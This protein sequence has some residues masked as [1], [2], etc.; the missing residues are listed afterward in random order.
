MAVVELTVLYCSVHQSAYIEKLLIIVRSEGTWEKLG[1]RIMNVAVGPVSQGS[2]EGRYMKAPDLAQG[3]DTIFRT[4]NETGL[5]CCLTAAHYLAQRYPNTIARLGLESRLLTPDSYSFRHMFLELNKVAGIARL[6]FNLPMS[7]MK[8]RVLGLEETD[9]R[10]EGSLSFGLAGL[11][12]TEDQRSRSKQGTAF[13]EASLVVDGFQ[14]ICQNAAEKMEFSS[15]EEV[16]LKLAETV[17]E[18]LDL[19]SLSITLQE[20]QLNIRPVANLRAMYRG[21]ASREL[22]S[23]L[24]ANQAQ[25]KL[26]LA[27]RASYGGNEPKRISSNAKDGVLQEP[28]FNAPSAFRCRPDHPRVLYSEDRLL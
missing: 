6:W 7:A 18:V 11:V 12:H 5:R 9:V 1:A 26:G 13:T 8:V 20:V 17:L 23:N 21:T 19:P 16:P 15:L 28:G 10:T 2:F 4:S 27:D 14:S 25:T 24:E 22:Q 3:F